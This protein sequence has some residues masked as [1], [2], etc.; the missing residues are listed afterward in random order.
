MNI[1]YIGEHLLPGMIGKTFIWISFT[2]AFIAAVLYFL[3]SR[4]KED[5]LKPIRSYARGFFILHV[6][7]LISVVIILY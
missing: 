3:N 6:F 5:R 1:H 2:A 4:N 7:S